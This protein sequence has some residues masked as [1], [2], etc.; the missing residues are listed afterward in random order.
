MLTREYLALTT[1]GRIKPT[2]RAPSRM[3]T[4]SEKS[5]MVRGRVKGEGEEV[6][7]KQHRL[8]GDRGATGQT[9]RIFTSGKS[10]RIQ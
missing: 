10:Y 3:Y 9:P 5:C 6:A 4:V 7:R 2:A 1:R 8:N